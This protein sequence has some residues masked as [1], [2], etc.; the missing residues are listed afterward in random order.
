VQTCERTGTAATD[1]GAGIA[2]GYRLELVFAISS[3]SSSSVVATANAEV[4]DWLGIGI[5]TS[6]LWGCGFNGSCNPCEDRQ[7]AMCW[8][9]GGWVYAPDYYPTGEPLLAKTGSNDV[10]GYSN[11]AMTALIVGTTQGSK[12]TAYA[13]YAAQQLPVLYEP[14]VAATTEVGRSVKCT[15]GGACA[16]SPVGNFMPEYM[17]Y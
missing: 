16:Q 6:V 7:A 4:S 1:C 5:K 9:G 12:L 8:W 17:H 2:K 13:R 15:V 10:G 3:P 11:P 14:V